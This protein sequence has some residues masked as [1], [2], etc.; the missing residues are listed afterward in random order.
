MFTLPSPLHPPIKP[1][2][3]ETRNQY[4]DEAEH[5]LFL[6]EAKE[7]DVE[8][9]AILTQTQQKISKTHSPYSPHFLL[10]QT[11]RKQRQE[12]SVEMKENT[13]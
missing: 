10:R 9:L 12:V 8:L 6:Y 11:S 7:G 5:R 1:E 2:E 4:W 13:D 3:A